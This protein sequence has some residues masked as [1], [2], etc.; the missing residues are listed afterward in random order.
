MWEDN[1]DVVM[2]TTMHGLNFAE[3]EEQSLYTRAKSLRPTA[4]IDYNQYIVRVDVGYQMLS[5]FHTIRRY[6]KAYKKIFFLF[7]QYDVEQL[8]SFKKL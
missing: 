2:L 3:T 4:V 5:K 7:Y 8:Y 1:K 6:K